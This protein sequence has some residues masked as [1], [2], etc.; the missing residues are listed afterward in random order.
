MKNGLV[1]PTAKTEK[2]N[3]ITHMYERRVI[4]K[5]QE[6]SLSQG[7]PPNAQPIAGIFPRK[8]TAKL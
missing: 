8:I 6:S 7:L 5:L 1:T 2:K 4:L 3:P